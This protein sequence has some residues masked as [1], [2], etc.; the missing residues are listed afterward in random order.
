MDISAA[1]LP[2]IQPA[3]SAGDR[4]HPLFS[5][6]QQY[7][8]SMNR[9]LVEASSFKD[10]LRAVNRQKSDNE[11]QKHPRFREWQQWMWDTQGGLAGKTTLTFPDNFSAWLEGARW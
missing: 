1:A 9:L 8:N 10:W 2:P 11:I 6:Y 7:R 3:I 5:D 4:A